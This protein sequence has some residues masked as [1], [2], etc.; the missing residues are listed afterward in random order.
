MP[1]SRPYFA[2]AT[3]FAGGADTP[4]DFLERCL[5][6]VAEHEPAIGAFVHLDRDAARQAAD[7]SAARWRA[8]RPL[9]PIDGMPVGIKDIM[10]TADM[11]TQ[12]GSDIFAGWRS[13]RD[14]AAVAALREAG[15]VILGKTVTTEFAAT[16]PRGTRN[17]WDLR[18]TP[19]GSSS[20]SAAA[21]AA[22]FVPAAL[23]TQVVGSIIRP[24]SYCGCIGFKPTVGAINRGGSHDYL[25]QSCTGVLAASLED[26]W[27][28]CRET[29]ARAG[30]DPGF[31][32][33]AGPAAM[34]PPAPPRRL[35]ILETP[36]WER[37]LPEA[38]DRLDAAL[39]RLE[40]AG[41][42][43]LRRAEEPALAAAEAGLLGAL[44][45]TRRIGAWEFRW[46]LNTYRERNAAALSRASLDR[47]AAAEAMTPEDY[48]AML[49]ERAR[50]RAL[51]AALAARCDGVVTLSTPGPAPE[52]LQ[53]TGDPIF[54]VPASLLGVP[55]LSLP[56]LQV[57]DLP[58]GLQLVGFEHGDAALFAVA[59]WLAGCIGSRT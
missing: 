13:G 22:G 31:P 53:S 57:G 56:L 38:R 25:S 8:G 27:H 28:V 14:A 24:A 1:L 17:P 21:V 2:A 47:L 39:R 16:E 51:W 20:G 40:A 49:A 10:E 52:G 58:L 37:A 44:D 3:A 46:P 35:A 43:L 7:R 9:S 45:L 30:G 33:L 11:P 6:S 26:A 12:M 50:V 4:R 19:G 41:V 29:A 42:T 5:A 55:A 59:A 15:A 48:R 32:G 18:R 54:C 36:G 23:G 34:P